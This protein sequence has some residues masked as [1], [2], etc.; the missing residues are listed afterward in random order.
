M[1]TNDAPP[2]APTGTESGRVT[3]ARRATAVAFLGTGF[4]FASWVSRLPQ[5]RTELQL[6]AA[7]LGF[8]LLALAGGSLLALP[9]VAGLIPRLGT[10]TV[11]SVMAV[12]TG[13]ALTLIGVGYRFGTA[14]VVLG[15]FL[16]GFGLAA[17][18]VAMNVQGAL[19]ERHARRAIMSRFHAGFSVATV[20]SALLG[21]G[22]IAIGASVTVHLVAIAIAVAV[23]VVVAAR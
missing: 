7:D 9:A 4:V 13:G 20:G 23:T 6:S 2:A 5:I 17:W 18:N 10:R 3:A 15:L 11:V 1:R 8:V 14:P 22:L 12:V 19:V 21:T 16:L